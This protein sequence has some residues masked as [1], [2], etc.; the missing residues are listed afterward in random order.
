MNEILAFTATPETISVGD[1]SNLRATFTL[2]EGC[3]AAIEPG[4]IV[5]VSAVDVPVSPTETTEYTLSLYDTDG[6]VVESRQRFVMVTVPPPPE[7]HITSFTADPASMKLGE[8]SSLLPV[9]ENADTAAILIDGVPVY[10]GVVS[11]QSYPVSPSATQTYELV[12]VQF[13]PSGSDIA[14]VTVTITV[15]TIIGY[16]LDPATPLPYGGGVVSISAEFTNGTGSIDHGVG[17]VSSG[18]PVDAAVTETEVFLLTVTDGASPDA[19]AEITVEVSVDPPPAPHITSFDADPET[20]APGLSSDLLPVFE[21]AELALIISGVNPLV[22]PEGEWVEEFRPVV[23]GEAYEVTPGA[24]KTYT[25]IVGNGEGGGFAWQEVT[26]TLTDIGPD[27]GRALLRILHDAIAVVTGLTDDLVRPSYQNDPPPRPAIDVDW[28]SFW[29]SKCKPDYSASSASHDVLGTY[30]TVKHETLDVSCSFYGPN[31]VTLAAV[32]DAGFELPHNREAFSSAGIGFTGT[33]EIVHL[34][35][36][37]N[38]R[39][40]DRADITV[41]LRREVRRIYPVLYFVGLTGSII[42]D[43]AHSTPLTN[44]FAVEEGE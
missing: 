21:D 40:Y 23:S 12:V 42:G 31:S 30:E 17:P 11:G 19:T 34:P 8:S 26:V 5:P 32:L 10:E 13:V 35:E 38:A 18:V 41:T 14:Q 16:T 28:C 24:T 22:D 33:S 36:L 7:P 15:P 3:R 29:I 37:I 9:F 20:I 27:Y 25:L 44:N 4:G 39:F 43:D 6:H 2:D 1:S